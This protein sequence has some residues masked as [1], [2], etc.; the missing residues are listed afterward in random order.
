[1]SFIG[2]ILGGQAQQKA[3]ERQAQLDERNATVT[4]QNAEQAYDVYE[5]YD[6][7]KFDELAE[8]NMG[9]LNVATAMSGAESDSG[10]N[11]KVKL[12]N[13]YKLE[14]DKV[15]LKYNAVV[16]REEGLNTAIMQRAEADLN[17]YRGKAAKQ[18][19]Y[20]KAIGSL[21]SDGKNV[22]LWGK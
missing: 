10:T 21:L 11:L 1:M 19:G 2:D 5:N 20:Y 4:K 7:P 17:R 15:M 13:A 18:A 8:E 16:K 22:G 14:N 12:D 6:R 3:F 9:A